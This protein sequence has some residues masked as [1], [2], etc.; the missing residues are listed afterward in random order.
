MAISRAEQELAEAKTRVVEAKAK[1]DGDE[2]ELTRYREAEKAGAGVRKDRELAETALAISE[3]GF[4]SAQQRVKTAELTI[5]WLKKEKQA[6]LAEVNVKRAE[7]QVAESAIEDT[8]IRAPFAGVVLLKQAEVGEAVS[9]G[10]VSGQVTSGA[11]FQLAD[12][13]SL[14]GEVDINEV[15][16]SKVRQGQPTEV[17]V[18]A[19][20]DRTLRG[21]VRLLMPGANRQKATVAAKIT[22]IDK[23]PRLKPDMSCKVIFL[24]EAAQSQAAPKLLVPAEAVRREGNASY[25]YVLQ[26]GTARKRGVEVGEAAGGRVEIRSGVKE[27]DEVLTSGV[28]EIRDGAAVRPQLP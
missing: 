9:P 28:A 3:A 2:R 1:R 18:D 10:V 20:P 24:R 22:L 19:I 26:N 4:A 14:E 27:G 23:D 6:A 8:V 17:Q 16:L 7:I 5:E 11:I 15:N 25:V 21:E 12:F 13:D